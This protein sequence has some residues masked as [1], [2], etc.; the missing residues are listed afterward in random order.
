MTANMRNEIDAAAVKRLGGK[1]RREPFLF[2]SPRPFGG[3]DWL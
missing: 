1:A 3:G 2:V